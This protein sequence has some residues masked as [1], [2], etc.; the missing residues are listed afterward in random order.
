MEHLEEASRTST[1][2][3][4]SDDSFAGPTVEGVWNK[5]HERRRR[6]ARWAATTGCLLLVAVGV[7]AIPTFT[8][9]EEP[10]A[11]PVAVPSS[12]EPDSD[13]NE[14]SVNSSAPA[15]EVLPVDPSTSTELGPVGGAQQRDRTLPNDF[16]EGIAMTTVDSGREQ[17]RAYRVGSSLFVESA[18][19]RDFFEVDLGD[20]LPGFDW[21]VTA[22]PGALAVVNGP[23]VRFL[24]T[25]RT[26]E[27]TE[28]SDWADLP[29]PFGPTIQDRAWIGVGNGSGGTPPT[30]YEWSLFDREFQNSGATLVLE[31]NLL[32]LLG[33]A[34]G[35]VGVDRSTGEAF[36][37]N[38]SLVGL[39][40][41][42][43]VALAGDF[44]VVINESTVRLQVTSTG[45]VLRSV[46]LSRESVPAS[47]VGAARWTGDGSLMLLTKNQLGDGSSWFNVIDFERETVVL[48]RDLG[49]GPAALWFAEK[50]ILVASSDGTA[51]VASSPD[52]I[53]EAVEL[54][55]FDEFFV[56]DV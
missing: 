15:D 1:R 54:P 4:G 12:A 46:E 43:P 42:F 24:T 17:A 2:P 28:L 14:V 13:V 53:F 36:A 29:G 50:E 19:S 8:R 35:L 6:R 51:S 5:I 40:S 20:Q 47:S 10:V 23:R 34:Q 41:G 44:V 45:E 3:R 30:S 26:S 11:L 21:Q 18:E 22:T 7:V 39:G 56:M 31:A 55:P 9:V 25:D 32:P 27:G 37:S 38:G 33:T 49:D 16:Y 48:E 52:A